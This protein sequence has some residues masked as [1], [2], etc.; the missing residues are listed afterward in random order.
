MTKKRWWIALVVISACMML[1]FAVGT[2]RSHPANAG[3][4]IDPTCTSPS[5]CIQYTNN[6]SGAGIEGLSLLG[7]AV[8]GVT[9][10][11]STS[12]S[13]GKAGIFGNDLSTAGAFDS[14]V[15]GLSVRGTGVSGQSTSGAGLMGISKGNN[16]VFGDSK[17][18]G[19]SGVYGQNDGGGFGVAGRIGK[20]GIAAGFFDA[21][22]TGSIALSTSSLNGVGANIIGGNSS[23]PALS[24][25]GNSGADSSTLA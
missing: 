16:G 2:Q 11:K 14:G 10:F 23:L 21:G 18:A 12:T 22:S 17:A 25:V 3:D 5:P 13:N 4:I 20:P 19:G 1:A 8:F 6:S 24:I 7:N 15:S 9:Q